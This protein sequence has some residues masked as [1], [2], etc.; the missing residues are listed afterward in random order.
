MGADEDGTLNGLTERRAIRDKII[1]NHRGRI[2]NTAGDSVPKLTTCRLPFELS[3][4]ARTCWSNRLLRPNQIVGRK[5]VEGRARYA[6]YIFP[7]GGLFFANRMVPDRP[8]IC[9]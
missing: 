1:G 8:A 6:T 4:R 3:L 5:R 9:G 2:A 7:T